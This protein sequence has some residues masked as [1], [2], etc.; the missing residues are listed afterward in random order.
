MGFFLGMI[1]SFLWWAWDT[2]PH[3][4]K[5]RIS[6]LF[7]Q[8]TTAQM[9]RKHI[10]VPFWLSGNKYNVLIK[11]PRKKF[12]MFSTILCDGKDRTQKI[13]KYLGPDNNF[14]GQKIS[15]SDFGFQNIEFHIVLPEEKLL[16][17]WHHQPI[18]I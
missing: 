6:Y 8:K 7:Q 5:D 17:F 3:C 2:T 11:R 4:V 14:F 9:T 18:E 16:S 10:K 13:Q 12:I 15:P 1:L